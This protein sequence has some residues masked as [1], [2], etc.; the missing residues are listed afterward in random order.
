[1]FRIELLQNQWTLAALAGGVLFVLLVVLAYI[2]V[3]RSVAES[4]ENPVPW[5]L[6]LTYVVMGVFVVAYTLVMAFHP[7]NW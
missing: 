1:M 5:V 6:I 2:A 3:W 7:P 4:R